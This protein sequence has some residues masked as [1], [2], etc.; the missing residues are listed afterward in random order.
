MS[1]SRGYCRCC[2]CRIWTANST[3]SLPP[4]NPTTPSRG[5]GPAT[6][7]RPA[8]RRV[9]L[10]ASHRHRSPRQVGLAGPGHL[11]RASAHRGDPQAGRRGSG[12]LCGDQGRR[13]A[14]GRA[15][16][17]CRGGAGNHRNGK[18]AGRGAGRPGGLA[19]VWPRRS[20]SGR[21]GPV[22]CRAGRVAGAAGRA[23]DAQDGRGRD[24]DDQR[25]PGVLAIVPD[26]RDVDALWQAATTR[27]DESAVVALSAGLGP[28]AHTAAGWPCCGA[29]RAW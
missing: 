8:G 15:G 27:I 14:A 5:A 10:G 21:A 1:R 29:P 12:A 13:A 28:A 11:R 18:P 17:A 19:S 20:V 24:A 3:I 6:V 9:H 2:R 22:A 25:G 23:V 16:A 26:Q 4:S 7:S